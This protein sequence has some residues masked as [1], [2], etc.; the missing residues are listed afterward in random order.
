MIRKRI[1]K[2][3]LYESI[4]R[5]VSKIVKRHLKEDGWSYT[6]TQDTYAV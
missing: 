2:R 1:N 6:S 5:D 3:S 4:M